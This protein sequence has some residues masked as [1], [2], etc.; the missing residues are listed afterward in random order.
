MDPHVSDWLHL[1]LRWLHIIAAVMWIGNSLFFAWLDRHLSAP[2][3]KKDGVEGELWMVHSGGFYQVE[4]KLV[5]PDKLPRVLHWFKWEAGFTWISGILLLIFLFYA[6]GSLMVDRSIAD[7]SH[8]QAVLLSIGLLVGG[9]V[10]YDLLMRS[11]LGKNQR[12]LAGVGFLLIGGLAYGLTHALSGRAAYIQIGAMLGTI[13]VAN[14]WMVIIPSQRHLVEATRAGR[15]PDP[16]YAKRAKL[17]SIH[18]HYLTFPVIFIM[19]SNH[20]PSTYGS[21]HA[22][23][24]LVVLMLLGAGVKHLM[25]VADQSPYLLLGG[26]GTAIMIAVF[27]SVLAASVPQ[28]EA[29]SV[30]MGGAAG[31]PGG[32]GPAPLPPPAVNIGGP[33]SPPAGVSGAAAVRGVVKFVGAAPV[34]RPVALP[35]G[36]AEQHKTPPLDSSLLVQG[37][38]LQGALV[39]VEG[40][41]DWREPPPAAE[42]VID[43][44]GCLYRPRVIAARVGQ[45]VVI[46]N[47]DP[48]VHNVHSEAQQNAAATFNEI[49]ATAGT[50]LVKTFARPE[51]AVHLKCDIHPWMSAYVGV[52]AHPY[53]AITDENGEFQLRNLAPGEY[54]LRAWHE[55]LGTQSQKL[56]VTASTDVPVELSFAA[57]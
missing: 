52:F 49:M 40:L 47:S 26:L 28:P 19:L 55:T 38:R 27:Y 7:I 24:V 11:P 41:A 14:V 30:A 23:L 54:T 45:P 21:A 35:S 12:L 9:W 44:F 22:W 31:E 29:G 8:L 36:C 25:N 48:L 5:A 17:R 2:E 53:F 56:T 18:N 32:K 20:F 46:L 39:Y 1:G 3:E 57:K 42:V 16:V 34:R 51:V 6:S 4:K 10:V 15:R 37:D 33:A 13:M 43:Q 50:R